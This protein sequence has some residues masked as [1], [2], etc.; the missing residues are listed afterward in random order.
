MSW[1]DLSIVRK[2]GLLLVLNTVLAVV[3]IAGVFTLGTAIARYQERS[4]QL[5]SLAQVVG[6]NSR[7]A[8]A[9]NDAEGARMTLLALRMQQDVVMAQLY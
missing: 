4:V 7:A 3:M 1:R 9:F 6:E 8:L 2:L 5:L